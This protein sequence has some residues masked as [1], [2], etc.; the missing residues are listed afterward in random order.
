MEVHGRKGEQQPAEIGER[1]KAQ[2][3]ADD[4]H[5]GAP[6]RQEYR[7]GSGT[8]IQWSRRVED[9]ALNAPQRGE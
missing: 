4:D 1:D 5:G 6:V 3:D 2:N 7:V 8:R 9:P